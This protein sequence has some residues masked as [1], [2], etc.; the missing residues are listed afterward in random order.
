MASFESLRIALSSG[1]CES[2]ESALCEEKK[3]KC[4][5]EFHVI[6]SVTIENICKQITPAAKFVILVLLTSNLMVMA[7]GEG[8]G[9]GKVKVK[10]MMVKAMANLRKLPDMK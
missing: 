1:S 4:S 5:L 9:N 3:S 6:L 7:N 2:V 10:A 8:K